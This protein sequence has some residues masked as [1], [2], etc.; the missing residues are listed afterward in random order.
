MMHITRLQIGL[1][2]VFKHS[3][4]SLSSRGGQV[5]IEC[6]LIVFLKMFRI[7]PVIILAFNSFIKRAFCVPQYF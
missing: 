6:D 3:K 5:H 1:V 2:F 4:K 7:L